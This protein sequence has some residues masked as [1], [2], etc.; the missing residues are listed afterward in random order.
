VTV[1]R[2]A[3]TTAVVVTGGASGIG[4]AT[5]RVLAAA[6]RPIAICDTDLAAASAAAAELGTS[7]DVPVEAYPVDVTDAAQ[8]GDVLRPARASL[9]PIG[10]LV[11]AAGTSGPTRLGDLTEEAWG[12]IVDVHLRALPLL[13]QVMLEDLR[14]TP[15]AAIVGVGSLASFVGFDPIPAY[16]AAKSGL[17]GLCRALALSLGRDGIRVNLVCPGY[18]DT[19]M[20]RENAL[21]NPEERDRLARAAPLGRLGTGVDVAEA[22]RFLLSDAASFITGTELVVDGGVLAGTP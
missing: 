12:R 11:H 2:D 16:C 20:L 17:R 8:L 22:I 10:G 13:V 9:G 14:A 4:L 19:P 3:P 5:A 7:Y 18:I 1:A 21:A 15:G 6:H